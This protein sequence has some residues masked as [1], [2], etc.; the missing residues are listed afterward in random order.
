MEIKKQRHLISTEVCKRQSY[1]KNAKNLE[2]LKGTA[3]E[4]VSPQWTSYCTCYYLW[5]TED[6]NILR[7][8]LRVLITEAAYRTAWFSTQCNKAQVWMSATHPERHVAPG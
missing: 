1:M 5:P 2:T 8:L 7:W 6:S 4:S 3:N